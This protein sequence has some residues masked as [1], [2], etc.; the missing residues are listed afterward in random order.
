MVEKAPYDA[1]QN[2]ADA[3]T[4]NNETRR[5]ASVSLQYVSRK[6][7]ALWFRHGLNHVHRVRVFFWKS[8][9]VNAEFHHKIKVLVFQ[10]VSV[11]AKVATRNR[12]QI[13]R[14]GFAK[15]TA[16]WDMVARQLAPLAA[17]GAVSHFRFAFPA[18]TLII[19][20]SRKALSDVPGEVTLLS[21][22]L[23]FVTS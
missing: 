5:I 7:E 16:G 17:V 19:T 11:V 21:S 14:A 4:I 10:R 12:D 22:N 9:P 1:A 2:N 20:L 15:K 13:A 18:H 6:T 8:I 23:R 3:V